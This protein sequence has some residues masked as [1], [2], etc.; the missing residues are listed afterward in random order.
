MVQFHCGTSRASTIAQG[1]PLRTSPG[2]PLDDDYETEIE[3][4]LA[5]A[6]LK[7]LNSRAAFL[8]MRRSCEHLVA[9]R[10]D[11]VASG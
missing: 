1:I 4:L 8:F 5:E 2:A 10:R 3:K 9:H 7:S 6:P 11:G